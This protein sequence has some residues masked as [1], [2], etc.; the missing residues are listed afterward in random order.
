MRERKELEKERLPGSTYEDWLS[1]QRTAHAP[2]THRAPAPDL[3]EAW[4][5]AR[6]RRRVEKERPPASQSSG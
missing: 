2:R 6:I 1:Q 4:V 5:E 3:Y